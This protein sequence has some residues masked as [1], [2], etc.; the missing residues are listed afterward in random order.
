VKAFSLFK[1]HS[2]LKIFSEGGQ[3]YSVIIKVVYPH[4]NLVQP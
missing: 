1:T 4:E 2:W 3:D